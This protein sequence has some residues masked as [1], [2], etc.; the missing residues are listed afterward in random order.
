MPIPRIKELWMLWNPTMEIW[1]LAADDPDPYE[2]YLC[3]T[4]FEAIVALQKHQRELYEITLVP[5]RVI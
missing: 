4:S 2:A 3:A 1:A 5:I